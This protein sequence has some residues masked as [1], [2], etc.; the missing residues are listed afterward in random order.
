MSDPIPLLRAIPNQPVPEIV[1]FLK[2][3]LA[4]AMEGRVQ[5]IGIAIRRDDGAFDTWW[6]TSLGC[7]FALATG[8]TRLAWRHQNEAFSEIVE[9]SDGA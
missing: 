9:T 6:H 3:I 8:I 4:R 7:D 1:A 5:G 2:D